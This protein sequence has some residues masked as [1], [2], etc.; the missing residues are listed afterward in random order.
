MARFKRE[1]DAYAYEVKRIAE[2]APCL[3]KHK[4]GN[5]SRATPTRACAYRPTKWEKAV[6][7]MGGT[8]VYAA[9]YLLTYWRHKINPEKLLDIA[10]VAAGQIPERMSHG[11]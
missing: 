2:Y 8:R 5:G 7:A 4:G 6:E 3:N 9:R 10:R 11:G 1:K